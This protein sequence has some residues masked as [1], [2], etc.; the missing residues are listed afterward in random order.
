M[1]YGTNCIFTATFKDLLFKGV[2]DIFQEINVIAKF[3]GYTGTNYFCGSNIDKYNFTSQGNVKR[4][5]AAKDRVSVC[6]Y[7]FIKNHVV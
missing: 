1:L 4:C 6:R 7:L 5:F 2:G 3:G